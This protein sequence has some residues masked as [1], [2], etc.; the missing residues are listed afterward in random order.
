[1]KYDREAVGAKLR[2]ERRRRKETQA[3]TAAAVGVTT[4]SYAMYETGARVPRDDV[5]IAI[6]DHFSKTVGDLFFPDTLT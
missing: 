2:I 1:M 3:E 4:A 5:K 6:A